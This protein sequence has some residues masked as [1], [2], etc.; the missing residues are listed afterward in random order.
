VTAPFVIETLATGHARTGVAAKDER[1]ATFHQHHGF[2]DFGSLP[3]RLVTARRPAKPSPC[4][5]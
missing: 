3:N 4:C 2:V 1:A 5:A